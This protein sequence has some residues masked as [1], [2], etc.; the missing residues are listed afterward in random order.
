MATILILSKTPKNIELM[1]EFLNKQGF[2]SVSASSYE[3]LDR[4]INDKNFDLA[5]LDIVGFDNRIWSYFEKIN[6]TD[7]PFFIISNLKNP[8][9]NS[10]GLKKGAK[11]V[12]VKPILMRELIDLIKAMLK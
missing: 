4:I 2:N 12:M 1:A 6:Q 10:E 8:K 5:L 11:G 3:D 9:I 7:K